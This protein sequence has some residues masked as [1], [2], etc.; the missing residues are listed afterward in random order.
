[1]IIKVNIHNNWL[2]YKHNLK[3]INKNVNNQKKK[4]LV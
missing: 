3:N 1:M 4:T 2:N